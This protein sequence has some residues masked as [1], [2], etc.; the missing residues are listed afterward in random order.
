MTTTTA[1]ISAVATRLKRMISSEIGDLKLTVDQ[2]RSIVADAVGKLSRSFRGLDAASGSQQ[3]ILAKMYRR[4]ST[5][6]GGGGVSFSEFA[7]ATDE[8]L[9]G[10]VQNIVRTSQTS[11]EMV[12]MVD[13]MAAHMKSMLGL[14]NDLMRITDQTNLLAL[15]AT[16]EAARAGERGKGF[17]VVAT[18][19][20]SLSKDSK[21][22][23]DKL[24]ELVRK[25]AKGMQETRT[26]MND[27]SSAD[28]TIALQAKARVDD[29]L[30]QVGSM[31]QELEGRVVEIDRIASTINGSVAQ[32][33]ISLQF[34]DIV[35]QLLEH[36][37]DRIDLVGKA[38]IDALS[39]DTAAEPEAALDSLNDAIGATADVLEQRLAAARRKPGT[40]TSVESGSVD[41]F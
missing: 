13:D 37:A 4:E 36:V 35:R 25:T 3:Q 41:L 40:Q 39:F 7:T 21:R 8:V 24:T 2:A 22:F 31:N 16:I 5:A 14:L 26:I 38:A 17:A 20:R 11:M 29:M 23:S 18:E 34:E 9:R 15:N 1:D 30:A 27:M 33:I 12:S 19:V 6:E 10:F 28:M 32:A